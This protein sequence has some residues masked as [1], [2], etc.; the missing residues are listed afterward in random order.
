MIETLKARAL[1]LRDR[2]DA[3]SLR[4]RALVFVAVMVVLYLVA[5][6]VVFGPLRTEQSSIERD[7]KTKRDQIQ[8]VEA[9]IQK[10]VGGQPS[11][12]NAQ[13]RAKVAT[14]Q[15]Q[16]K[17]L[18][19][20]MEQM[21]SGVVSPKE[22]AKLIERMLVQNRALQLVK[23]ESLPPAPIT[24][25]KDSRGGAPIPVADVQ[26]YKHG[27]RVELRGRYFDIVDYLKALEALPWKVFWGEVTLETEKY[28]SSKVTL[29]IYTLSRHPGWIGV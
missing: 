1:E 9:Q 26:I 16:V 13:N 11:D 29:V 23:L 19:A 21:T 20:A 18:D 15:Q 2:I 17:E 27:M 22:M 8:S 10:L 5:V 3:F 7:L 12:V 24:D 25:A 4:E 6:N 28:P 14:L